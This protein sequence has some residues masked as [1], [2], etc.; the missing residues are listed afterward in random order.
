[1]EFIA[2]R[3]R[4]ALSVG[5][6]TVS[7]TAEELTTAA[8]P[9]G[10][11]LQLIEVPQTMW[12]S[13]S[14]KSGQRQIYNDPSV[15][16]PSHHHKNTNDQN[17]D[18]RNLKTTTSVL[19]SLTS[20]ISNGAKN[21]A[22]RIINDGQI[23]EKGISEFTAKKLRKVLIAKIT[24]EDQ[25]AEEL[26]PTV[27][28]YG[29]NLQLIEVPQ[30]MWGSQ[31]SGD[32]RMYNDPSTDLPSHHHNNTNDQSLDTQNLQTT[33]PI[34]PLFNEIWRDYKHYLHLMATFQQRLYIE[35][36]NISATE[37]KLKFCEELLLLRLPN[38]QSL[39]L[40]KYIP[41]EHAL[42][43]IS[44]YMHLL[45]HSQ[46]LSKRLPTSLSSKCSSM[47]CQDRINQLILS[48]YQLN[49]TSSN[50][51]QGDVRALLNFFE[52][53]DQMALS[54]H[55]QLQMQASPPGN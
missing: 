54:S 36:Q 51:S 18:T 1:S 20:A 33:T 3:L 14:Q 45:I 35:S 19:P 39:L 6:A 29:N 26:T 55:Q 27:N 40:G 21:K 7:H 41:I 50:T 43:F 8:N 28:P 31:R 17:L 13:L 46:I 49:Q 23:S 44:N 53:P 48:T 2:K 37:E 25:A 47:K 5:R 12:G 52:H 38:M 30:I 24:T 22:E 4:E 15:D 42:Q 9:N 11:N 32:R 16:L 10:N 34:I